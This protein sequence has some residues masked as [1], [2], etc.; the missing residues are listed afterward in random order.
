M[1]R[2]LVLGATGYI[3]GRLVPRLILKG[4]AV[5]CLVRNPHKLRDRK[6]PGVEIAEG[7]VL[8]PETLAAAM[9]GI[10][11]VYYLVHSLQAGEKKFEELD[12]QAAQNA[13]DA[14]RAAGVKRII[15]LGGL[16]KRGEETSAHL[17][18]RH[19]VGDILRSSDVPVTEFRAAVIIGSGGVSFEMMHHLVNRLPIMICPKWIFVKTQPI[20]VRDVLHYLVECLDISQSTGRVLDIGGPEILSYGDMMKIIARVLGLKRVLIPVPFLT[21]TLSSYWINW[22]TPIP[23]SIART[24][25]GG[26]K[27]ETICENQN[28]KNMFHF[29]LTPFEE[30]VRRSFGKVNMHRVETRWTDAEKPYERDE[31]EIDPSHFLKDIR[32]RQA[33]VP[34][35]KLFASVQSIGGD[36]G[37]YA[38]NG[39]WRIRG[40]IDKQIGG[41]G[42]RRG[43]R[44]P[45]ELM[46]GD[47]L[48]FWRV[49]DFVPGHRL[50]L[51]AE[52]KLPGR[53]WLD[54]Q[55]EPVDETHSRLIQTARFYPHGLL[56][57]AYWYLLGPLH[58]LVFNGMADGIVKRAKQ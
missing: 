54:F 39:L 27:S 38:V 22:V 2:I 57:L 10:D 50:V 26:L 56:G 31:E 52:M 51:R 7:D 25:I 37:W 1:S 47:A 53:A 11:V 16:G 55:V 9:Q 29:R 13:A 46:V 28:A 48:D 58:V 24:L 40:F 5:R 34:A 33:D 19:Q 49:E 42:L 17:R 32:K 4:H 21:P 35:S 14:A 44:H 43:R 12:R 18:S 30:S 3:G 41:V 36:N 23:K 20:S 15:Y 8:K 6:W 45:V